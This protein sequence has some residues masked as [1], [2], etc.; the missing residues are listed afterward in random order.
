[1]A[2]G[3]ELMQGWAD[4]LDDFR[5]GKTEVSLVPRKAAGSSSHAN[6]TGSVPDSPV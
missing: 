1:V 6:G 3:K 4:L 2:E 5:K